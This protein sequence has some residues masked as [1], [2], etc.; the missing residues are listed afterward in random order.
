MLTLPTWSPIIPNEKWF[1]FAI[2][3]IE[4]ITKPLDVLYERF[5]LVNFSRFILP[6]S[7]NE[8]TSFFLTWGRVTL[9]RIIAVERQ[10]D[11]NAFSQYAT[12]T[13]KFNTGVPV[14]VKAGGFSS[15]DACNFILQYAPD[16]SRKS[17]LCSSR[18]G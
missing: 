17:A 14:L 12:V 9:L 13:A 8:F 7:T 3:Y 10:G 2:R 1:F 6:M 11:L 18:S 15:W 16:F 5:V 4:S